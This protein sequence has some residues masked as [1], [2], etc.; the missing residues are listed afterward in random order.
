MVSLA[1]T[2]KYLQKGL[3]Q[4]F[5]STINLAI[6]KK[7]RF[8]Y[9]N[10]CEKSKINLHGYNRQTQFIYVIT[11]SYTMVFLMTKIFW[12]VFLM[13]HKILKQKK[14]FCFFICENNEMLVVQFL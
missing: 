13:E 7:L 11:A 2:K 14:T 12:S 6:N 8:W 3:N 9:I 1:K 10:P 4:N 5:Q